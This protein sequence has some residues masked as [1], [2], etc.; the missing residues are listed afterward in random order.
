MLPQSCRQKWREKMQQKSE[1]E[2]GEGHVATKTPNEI[3]Y[4]D[5]T[6]TGCGWDI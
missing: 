2:V 6:A 4:N 1:I 5:F 3:F